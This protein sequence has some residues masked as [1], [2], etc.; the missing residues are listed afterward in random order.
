MD[1]SKDT[2]F[3]KKGEHFSKNDRYELQGILK[4]F[5]GKPSLRELAVMLNC[6]PNTVRN[7]LERGAHPHTGKYSAARAQRDYETKHL[8]SITKSRRLIAGRFVAW[9][10][11]MLLE[12]HWS[13]DVCVGYAKRHN[14]FPKQEMVCTKTLYNYVDTKLLP[15]RNIDLP[16]KVRRKNKSN[17]VR[18]HLKILGRSI[19]ERPASVLTRRSFGHWEIDTVIG[20]KSKSDNVVLSLAERKT[21]EYISLKIASKS[22]DGVSDGISY[23]RD[24]FGDKFSLV[25]KSIT[26]DNGSEFADLSKLEEDTKTKV[27][28]AHPYTASERPSN[29]RSN[30]LL[31]RFIPKGKRI[32]SYDADEILMVSDWCNDLPRKILNYQTP[33]DLFEKELDRIYAV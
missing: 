31:R 7:E 30:G 5:P 21:R 33:G 19:D 1:Y 27:Y 22:T 9:V 12:R 10:S 15:I 20:S 16:L 8:N 29:E 3:H 17:R 14:L 32:D 23:L 26:S 6:A 11:K 18:Q 28:F 13:L 24:L 4:A 2:T 25:F